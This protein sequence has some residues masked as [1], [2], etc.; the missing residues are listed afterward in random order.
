MTP[1]SLDEKLKP[2]VNVFD[3]G[4]WHCDGDNIDLPIKSL[5]P[6]AKDYFFARGQYK[7][8]SGSSIKDRAKELLGK[9]YVVGEV[10]DTYIKAEHIC[11]G[12]TTY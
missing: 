12:C 1:T 6:K 9:D 4:F 11:L 8:C 2:P 10:T 7:D 5:T 3:N